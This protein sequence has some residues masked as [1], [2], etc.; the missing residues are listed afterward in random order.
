M[1]FVFDR[2]VGTWLRCH[3]NAFAFFGGVPER[4]VPDSPRN[5]DRR[6]VPHRLARL[7][8]LRYRMSLAFSARYVVLSSKRCVLL[9]LCPR[10]CQRVVKH[11]KCHPDQGNPAGPVTEANG[12]RT[13]RPQRY[14]GNHNLTRLVTAWRD[15]GGDDSPVWI[16]DH[17][18]VSAAIGLDHGNAVL[19][20]A[21]DQMRVVL[22]GNFRP[23]V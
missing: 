12:E 14:I 18:I 17:R 5:T 22:G 8:G 20:G 21:K 10:L 2:S 13:P 9:A 23:V 15:R 6:A 7:P 4:V 11:E 16:N 3:R 1:G 19:N